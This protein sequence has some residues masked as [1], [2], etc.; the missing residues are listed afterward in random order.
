MARISNAKATDRIS[1]GTMAAINKTPT[2]CS[3]I[4]A[5]TINKRLGGIS[6]PRTDDPATTPTENRAVYPC[7]IISGV[8][9]RVKTAADAI[10]EP[11]IAAKSAFAAT[12]AMPRPPRTRLRAHRAT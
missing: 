10:E 2:D 6:I 3:A 9:T 5:Y 7:V 1:P 8:A 4:N 11:V 12:V